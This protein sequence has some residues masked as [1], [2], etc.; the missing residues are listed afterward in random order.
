[1]KII[2]IKL[3]NSIP[4]NVDAISHISILNKDAYIQDK[5]HLKFY[6]LCNH[7]A[8]A[9]KVDVPDITFC[10]G[11]P[12]HDYLL[13]RPNGSLNSAISITPQD[14]ENL[15][16]NLLVISDLHFKTFEILFGIMAHE[17][18][19]FWQK[20]Y[21]YNYYFNS[22]NNN[23]ED[24][25]EIDADAFA[26]AAMSANFQIT[27][28]EAAS[29]ICSYE[30]NYNPDLFGKKINEAQFFLKKNKS[31]FQKIKKFFRRKG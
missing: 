25:A 2:N 5:D 29:I 30:K 26:I 6:Q 16:H 4:E 20:K 22:Y 27:L 21:N 17:F 7:F 3:K 8:K 18:R 24:R 19:H 23:I 13:L 9:L 31:P 15:K 1:M 14:D 11:S 12:V 28:E 10:N